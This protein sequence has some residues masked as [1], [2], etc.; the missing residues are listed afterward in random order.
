MPEGLRRRS[1]RTESFSEIG[2]SKS[3]GPSSHLVENDPGH[4]R[5]IQVLLFKKKFLPAIRSGHKRQTLRF[6]KWRLTRAGQRSYIPG[7][8][9]IVI[10]QVEEVRLEDLTEA[11]AVADGF[12]TLEELRTAL[13]E[14]YPAQEAAGRKLFRVRFSLA[15][16]NPPGAASAE[17]GSNPD[18]PPAA[19]QAAITLSPS[20]DDSSHPE[21]P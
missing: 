20:E 8:G 1:V 7:V 11:D 12:A 18:G 4:R 14:L 19:P 21:K 3:L 17:A 9:H 10:E 15:A 5:S 16:G 2:N 6:W 13:A